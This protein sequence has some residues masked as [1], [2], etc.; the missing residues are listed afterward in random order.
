MDG[1]EDGVC[2]SAQTSFSGG[3]ACNTKIRRLALWANDMG[4]IYIEGPGYENVEANWELAGANGGHIIIAPKAEPVRVHE[5]SPSPNKTKIE[6]CKLQV[7]PITNE[8]PGTQLGCKPGK[9]IQSKIW[10]GME[11]SSSHFPISSSHWPKELT[12]KTNGL[13]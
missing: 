6:P 3:I 12:L 8:I 1:F 11:T 7:G 9:P 2:G 4:S 10:S 13:T 5:L